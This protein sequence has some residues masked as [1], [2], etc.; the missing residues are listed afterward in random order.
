MTPEKAVLLLLPAVNVALPSLSA[1]A[2]ANDA[3]VWLLPARSSVAPR[4]MVMA[5]ELARV[6]A[7]PV[8][9]VPSA[10]VVAPR[11]ALDGDSAVNV[12]VPAPDLVQAPVPE[13]RPSIVRS[14]SVRN[15]A[16]ALSI[17]TSR[18]VLSA[19]VFCSAPPSKVTEEPEAPRLPSA[20]MAIVPPEMVVPPL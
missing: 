14:A 4:A 15:V 12:S 13:S 10:M 8:R 18:E 19:A 5:L 11:L 6:F 2:P 3:T 1:P 20:D 9:T 7:P 17:R 16:P